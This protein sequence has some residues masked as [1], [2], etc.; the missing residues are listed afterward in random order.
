MTDLYNFRGEENTGESKGPIYVLDGTSKVDVPGG[1]FTNKWLLEAELYI[2][3][4]AVFYC[5]GSGAGGDCDEL[6]IES[7][8]P[9]AFHEASHLLNKRYYPK[10]LGN[11]LA[12]SRLY[13]AAVANCYS[14]VL[15]H[16]RR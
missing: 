2:V 12:P 5:K 10:T 13:L 6:R 14:V 1:K 9:N 4:G 3:D 8:G 15:F 11:K 16:A 7:T